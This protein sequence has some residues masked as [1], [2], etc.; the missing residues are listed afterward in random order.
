MIFRKYICFSS[1]SVSSSSSGNVYSQGWPKSYASSFFK[2][3]TSVEQENDGWTRFAIMD[4]DL[5]NSNSSCESGDYVVV[6]GMLGF[7]VYKSN[8]NEVRAWRHV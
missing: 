3:N 5:T 7:S 8:A 2:C 6:K 4:V 1:S